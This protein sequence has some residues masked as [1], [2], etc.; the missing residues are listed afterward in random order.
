MASTCVTPKTTTKIT[1]KIIPSTN[2][3]FIILFLLFFFL[4][5][6]LLIREMYGLFR[7]VY[8]MNS[9]MTLIYRVL[10]MSLHYKKNRIYLRISYKNFLAVILKSQIATNKLQI[11]KTQNLWLLRRFLWLNSYDL[12]FVDI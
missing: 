8:V 7:F 2:C 12:Y 4:L 5:N 11:L 10:E 3:I 6:S 9:I 1:T